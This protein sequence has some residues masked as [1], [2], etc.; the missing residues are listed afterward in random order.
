[1]RNPFDDDVVK[2]PFFDLTSLLNREFPPTEWLV[3]SLIP[4]D[5]LVAISGMPGSYKSWIVEHLALSVAT[6]TTFLGKFSSMEG[7]VLIIDQ[8]NHLSLVQKRFKLL[9]GLEGLDIYFLDSEFDIDNEDIIREVCTFIADNSIKLVIVD[10]LIRSY[11][12]KDE[13][14]SNDMAEVFRQLKKLQMEGAAVVFVHHNRKPS[15]FSKGVT[16]ESMRGSSDIL[17]AVDSAI[18]VEKD[19]DGIKVYQTKLRHD[20]AV[21]PFKIRLVG[22]S[23]HLEFEYVGE[24]E[25]EAEKVEQARTEILTVL[26]EG[27]ISRQELIDRFKG[28]YGSKTIDSALKAFGEQELTVR[29]GE[30]G[31]KYFSKASEDLFSS[32]SQNG[33]TYM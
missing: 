5:A 15:V 9:G 25:E 11:R 33:N 29:T 4:L 14:S 10:S 31:K 13:N 23:E 12:K 18:A 2:G 6:G 32:A 24:V 21:K 28:M 19:K 17:A 3:E 20:L 1:M 30:H 22:D 7:A 27:E 16:A 26:E 8:E